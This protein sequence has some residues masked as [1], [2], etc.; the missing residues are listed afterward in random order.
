MD[1]KTNI[2]KN[3]TILEYLMLASGIILVFLLL[4]TGFN[5]LSKNFINARFIMDSIDKII[6]SISVLALIYVSIIAFYFRNKKMFK[7][8]N[9]VK[10]FFAKTKILLT[11][12]FNFVVFILFVVFVVICQKESVNRFASKWLTINFSWFNSYFKTITISFI[13][14]MS[15]VFLILSMIII[16]ITKFLINKKNQAKYLQEENENDKKIEKKKSITS[17]LIRV[18]VIT[19]I[20]VLILLAFSK[21]SNLRILENFSN[22][23]P[24]VIEYFVLRKLAAISWFFAI[25]AG[26]T[27]FGM[28]FISGFKEQVVEREAVIINE[29]NNNSDSESFIKDINNRVIQNQEITNIATI[30]HDNVIIQEKELLQTNEGTSSN[31][32]VRKISYYHSFEFKLK[33][34][35][36]TVKERYNLIRNEILK[37]KKVSMIKNKS[38][39]TYRIGYKKLIKLSL[40]GKTLRIYLALDISNYDVN[41]YH[42]KDA[43]KYKKYIEVPF[44]IKLTSNRSVN[45][46]LSLIKDVMNNNLIEQRKIFNEI[47]YTELLVPSSLEELEEYKR[48]KQ[49]FNYKS[50]N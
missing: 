24:E 45:K 34:A 49:P 17:L 47:N 29:E 26:I 4:I 11:Y 46:T 22:S 9:Y 12:I 40:V 35:D 19:G 14:I 15:L 48:L 44:M 23:M 30:K 28:W 6:M 42:Q 31:D 27:Y 43:S 50:N 25:F 41:K 33:N 21:N 39:E 7:S 1:K 37:Y 8:M 16:Y 5:F 13:L 36:I 2:K 20:V 18:G 3:T 32:A 10:G 38:G